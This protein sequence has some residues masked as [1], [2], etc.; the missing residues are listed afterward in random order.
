MKKIECTLIKVQKNFNENAD[1][2][3]INYCQQNDLIPTSVNISLK[4]MEF[5]FEDYWNDDWIVKVLTNFFSGLGGVDV[6]WN[7]QIFTTIY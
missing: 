6:L 2:L 3:A 5:V 4:T 7:N 1:S